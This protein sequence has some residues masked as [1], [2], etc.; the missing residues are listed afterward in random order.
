MLSHIAERIALFYFF[1][2]SLLFNRLITVILRRYLIISVSDLSRFR[3]V[4]FYYYYFIY[5]GKFNVYV[6]LTETLRKSF[7]FPVK[8][9]YILNF[10]AYFDKYKFISGT[11][12]SVFIIFKCFLYV[13]NILRKHYVCLSFKLLVTLITFNFGLCYIITSKLIINQ[14]IIVYIYLT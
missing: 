7:V 12:I 14:I 4:T 2:F 3:I 1:T 9:I 13:L 6:T 8:A 11:F 5:N 10:T